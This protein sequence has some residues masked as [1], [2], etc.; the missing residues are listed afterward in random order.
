MNDQ[1]GIHRQVIERQAPALNQAVLNDVVKWALGLG[2]LQTRRNCASGCG[3]K[4]G[5]GVPYPEQP[6]RPK[7]WQEAVQSPVEETGC[8]L[9]CP[10]LIE[11]GSI[12]GT[13]ACQARQHGSI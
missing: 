10:A 8:A 12:F 2:M 7:V 13:G 4:I 3:R 6:T 5:A 9:A 11:S 1:H